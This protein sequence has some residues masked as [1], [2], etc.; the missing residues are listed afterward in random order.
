MSV[1]WV[2]ER[3]KWYLN[4]ARIMPVPEYG[5]RAFRAGV[6]QI[7]RSRLAV[8]WAPGQAAQLLGTRPFFRAGTVPDDYLMDTP[9]DSSLFYFTFS[10]GFKSGGFEMKGL[11]IAEFDPEEEPS[12]VSGMIVPNIKNSEDEDKTFE[13]DGGEARIEVYTE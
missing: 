6:Q 2:V 3:A 9:I 1:E 5:L 4:R 11:E 7:E 8:G 10:R 13:V 12:R